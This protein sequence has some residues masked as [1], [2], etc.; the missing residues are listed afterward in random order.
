MKVYAS[1]SNHVAF[2]SVTAVVRA[3][4]NYDARKVV[5]E[6]REDGTLPAENAGLPWGTWVLFPY[7]I[8]HKGSLYVRLYPTD[9]EHVKAFF[10]L[11]GVPVAKSELEGICTASEFRESSGTDCFTV[12]QEILTRVG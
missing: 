1:L 3:G 8:T 11:D 12:R 5:K 9:L 4:V 2:K 7:V 10:T 6:A